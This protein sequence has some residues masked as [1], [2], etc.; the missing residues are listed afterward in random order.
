MTPIRMSAL[1]ALVLA[2]AGCASTGEVSRNAPIDSTTLLAPGQVQPASL[3]G[4]IAA[5]KTGLAALGPL[6][7]TGVR[8]SVPRSLEVDERNRYYP[9]GDI[10]WREDPIGDRHE[11]VA[12]IVR[13]ALEAGTSPL[14][15]GRA[16]T[17]DVE[18]SRFHALTEKARYTFGGV[19][20][21][22]FSYVL[23]DADTGAALIKP[24]F[25]RADF[26]ALGG[27]AAIAAEAKG[28]TQKVRITQHLAQ[29]ISEELVSGR[30]YVAQDL[31]FMGALNRL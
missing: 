6:H 26:D 18:V 21:I 3:P 19:H 27:S 2:V 13:D 31:G 29:V 25:I 8:V 5:P 17:L 20:A 16:V 14:K 4:D 11:Q 28:I 10:V 1:A 30:G 9:S 12:V 7:V 15:E 23:R 22:Q 24:R